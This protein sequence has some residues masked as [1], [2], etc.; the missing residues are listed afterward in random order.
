MDNRKNKKGFDMLDVVRIAII[1]SIKNMTIRVNK[2]NMYFQTPEGE[3]NMPISNFKAQFK[4]Q[5]IKAYDMLDDLL[6]R[7]E[8]ISSGMMQDLY[9]WLNPNFEEMD[10][11][12]LKNFKR[13]FTERLKNDKQYLEYIKS[14]ALENGK[15]Y[16]NIDERKAYVDFFVELGIFGEREKITLEYYIDA[17]IS[18]I[19]SVCKKEN[20]SLEDRSTLVAQVYHYERKVIKRKNVIIELLKF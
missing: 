14:L 6:L 9:H 11:E 12:P 19:E 3:Y 13:N 8:K 7:Q 2:G 1:D 17:P 16:K 20:L 15:R 5:F 18:K 10:V 4:D